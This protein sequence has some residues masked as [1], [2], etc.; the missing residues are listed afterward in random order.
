[1][2]YLHVAE[3]DCRVL[4]DFKLMAK[5]LERS[6]VKLAKH[7][8][9]SIFRMTNRLSRA[10]NHSCIRSSQLVSPTLS[11]ERLGVGLG[12]GVYI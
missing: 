9:A 4:V 10:T 2:S 7:N 11:R 1:M 5:K 12:Y 8:P 3:Q 6:K